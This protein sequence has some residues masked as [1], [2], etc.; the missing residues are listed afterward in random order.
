[1]HILLIGCGHMGGSLAN[2]WLSRFDPSALVTVYDPSPALGLENPRDMQLTTTSNLADLSGQEFTHVVFAVK[3]Q[4]FKEAASALKETLSDDV[5]VVS[6]MAGVSVEKIHQY[7]PDV[8]VVR[9]MPN[10]PAKISESMTGLYT[11]AIIDSD[12]VESLFTAVGKVIWLLEEP[13]ID[14]MTAAAGSGPGFI[15]YMM[16]CYQKAVV[17]LGFE[18]AEARDIVVQT[19]LGAAQFAGQSKEQFDALRHQ[20]TSPGGTTEVGLKDLFKSD[21]PTALAA[22]LESASRHGK[23]LSENS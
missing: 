4:Q 6:V 11:D 2:G 17:Q 22:A 21:L 12:V 15:F 18:E 8:T 20:V 3:P 16:E 9:A 5:V 23:V 14:A 10:L 19:F 13:Q 1:M 7:L